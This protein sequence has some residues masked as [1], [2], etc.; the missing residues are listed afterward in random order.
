MIVLMRHARTGG[1]QGRCIGRTP[2]DI[3]PE[4]RRQA[5]ELAGLLGAAGFVRLC[6]SPSGR[7]VD[8]LAPLAARCGIR[9]EV[10]PGLD[11]I[12]MGEWDGLTF[13]DIRTR[14]PREYERRGR[15][16]A[17]FRAP[18]GESFRQVA[19]R[20]VEVLNMLAAGPQPVLAVSHA[21]VIRAASCLLSG[22]PLD[23]LFSFR[24]DHGHS[25]VLQGLPGSLGIVESNVPPEALRDYVGG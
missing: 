4:G 1:G 15:Q 17:D 2:L 5:M 19:G 14:F 24:P 6:S 3:S 18:G 13:A 10:L 9:P 12:D 23:E 20:A 16:F 7:A 21:G 22:H 8:T 11:E 25:T